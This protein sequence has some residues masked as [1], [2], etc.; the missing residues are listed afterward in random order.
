MA[1]SLQLPLSH[2]MIWI[3]TLS[4]DQTCYQAIRIG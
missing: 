3:P 1:T 4:W 2:S